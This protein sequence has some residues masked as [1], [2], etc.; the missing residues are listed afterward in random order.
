MLE[1]LSPAD[2]AAIEAHG[3]TV[4]EVQRQ[5]DAPPR[6]AGAPASRPRRHRRRRHRAPRRRASMR[7]SSPSQTRPRGPDV[8]RSSCPP[9]APR[10]GC[11]R[12]SSTAGRRI[13]RREDSSKART[14]SPSRRLDP[15]F[16]RLAVDTQGPPAVPPV[17]GRAT[18]PLS[19]NTLREA[20]GTVRDAVRALPRPFHRVARAP[21]RFRGQLAEVRPRVERA[22]G[23]RFSTSPSPSNPRHRHDRRGRGRQAVPQGVRRPPLPSRRTRRAPEEPR[24]PRASGR[25]PR[26]RE[27]RR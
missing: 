7:T 27:E 17:S 1:N 12:S 10:A 6:P 22:T 4:A 25:R 21:Q 9:P 23:A 11:S 16:D 5:L 2:R 15:D 3:L 14:R 18:A 20:A 26:P 13:R 8:S 19:K 24:R